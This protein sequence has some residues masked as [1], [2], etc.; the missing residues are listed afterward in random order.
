MSLFIKF[1]HFVLPTAQC[2]VQP[3]LICVE[4]DLFSN[5][6]YSGNL[7]Y[8]VNKL[9]NYQRGFEICGNNIGAN[10]SKDC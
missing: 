5:L 10:K 7:N 3:V 1:S 9:V 4:S 6:M 2:L 8:F